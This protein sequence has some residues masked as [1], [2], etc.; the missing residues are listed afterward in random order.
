MAGARSDSQGVPL[1]RCSLDRL[2]VWLAD[3]AI[4]I[5]ASHL[6][7]L[8][9]A[10]GLSFQRTSSWKPS[11][12]P[13]Y[14][15]RAAR[16]LEL[17]AAAPF[18]GL[19]IGFDQMGPISLNRSGRRVHCDWLYAECA[20]AVPAA[21]SSGSC[22]RSAWSI[23]PDNGSTGSRTTPVRTGRPDIRQSADENK[24]ELV[25]TRTYASYLNRIERH[26]RPIQEFVFNNTDHRDRDAA[27]KA[28]AD[29]ITHRNGPDHDRRIAALEREHRVA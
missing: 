17:D 21:T 25:S 28:V 3:Q 24:I 5:S 11:P 2:S 15:A 26:F 29:Y 1:T 22:A 8:L 19:V 13:E 9:A 14:E 12:G 4:Q 7:R 27:G 20:P 6:G 16:V 18:D 23:S 10:A